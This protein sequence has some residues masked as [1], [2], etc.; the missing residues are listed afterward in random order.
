[1]DWLSARS[2]PQRVSNRYYR[3]RFDE[4]RQVLMKSQL[5]RILATPGLSQDT[6]EI[7]SL[8]LG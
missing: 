8:S 3:R 6:H 4:R 2:L 5:Q 1:M 7:A